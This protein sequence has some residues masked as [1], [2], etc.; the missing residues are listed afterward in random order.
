MWIARVWAFCTPGAERSGAVD[1]CA[2]S[3]R[4]IASKGR[5]GSADRYRRRMVPS[6]GVDRMGDIAAPARDRSICT[7]RK[8]CPMN[9]EA[10]IGPGR[11]GGRADV[12]CGV[13]GAAY[14]HIGDA[15]AGRRRRGCRTVGEPRDRRVCATATSAAPSYVRAP[16]VARSQS[17][18]GT[19]P[20]PVPLA[21]GARPRAG[22]GPGR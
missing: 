22:V 17:P 9:A 20:R 19:P 21:R 14:R 16:S 12:R 15:A 3:G 8:P 6:A 4:A 5:R 7:P 13:M 10:P 2:R 18:S 1:M 11:G